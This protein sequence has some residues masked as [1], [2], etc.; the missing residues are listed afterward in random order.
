MPIKQFPALLISHLTLRCSNEGHDEYVCFFARE[1]FGRRI[2]FGLN[3][4]LNRRAGRSGVVLGVGPS[5][6]D[7]PPRCAG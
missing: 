5:V 7:T 3:S 4:M 2:F 6:A 1:G